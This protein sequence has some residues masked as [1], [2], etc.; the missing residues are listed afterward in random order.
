MYSCKFLLNVMTILYLF[1]ICSCNIFQLHRHVSVPLICLRLCN[2]NNT[3][4]TDNKPTL[5]LHSI[6]PNTN[7]TT[8]QNSKKY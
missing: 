8:V 6:S 2:P 4:S 1:N 3:N 5:F 7:K